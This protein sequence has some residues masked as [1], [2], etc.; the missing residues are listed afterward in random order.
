MTPVTPIA[1]AHVQTLL[2]RLADGDRSA[3]EPAFVALGPLVRAFAARAL[4]RSMDAE[5]AAQSALT[6]LFEQVR[7][8]DPSRDGVAW[9]LAVVHFECRTIARRAQRRR[10]QALDPE[11]HAP[12]TTDTPESLM[13]RRELEAMARELFSDLGDDDARTIAAAIEDERPRADATFR[14]RLQRALARLRLA[15]RTKHGT[16]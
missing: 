6:K 5:D 14:K 15:W 3:I 8:F 9:A 13:G 11:T 12:S 16:E 2:Q 4:P 10:E 1:R 7:D